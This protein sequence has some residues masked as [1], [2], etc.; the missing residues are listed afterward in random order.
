MLNSIVVHAHEVNPVDYAIASI[1]RAG[2]R[3]EEITISFA[4]MIPR[5][6]KAQERGTTFPLSTE[7]L[8][9]VMKTQF[10]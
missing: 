9:A 6:I 7:N 10:T 2:L 3:N 4:K 1:I 8:P 5:K